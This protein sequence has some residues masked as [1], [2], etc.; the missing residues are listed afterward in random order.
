M[1]P[2]FRNENTLQAKKKKKY[3]ESWRTEGNNKKY[4]IPERFFKNI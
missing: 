1:R 4:E 2:T 3:D